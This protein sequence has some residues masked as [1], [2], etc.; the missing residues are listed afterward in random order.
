M[1]EQVKSSLTLSLCGVRR[2]HTM[3]MRTLGLMWILCILV[4][5]PS[6]KQLAARQSSHH[7]WPPPQWPLPQSVI[8]ADASNFSWKYLQDASIDRKTGLG[9]ATPK[10]WDVWFDTGLSQGA[11]IDYLET[12]LR[13]AGFRRYYPD[14]PQSSPRC[15]GQYISADGLIE[16]ITAA[17]PMILASQ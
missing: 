10:I 6:C 16:V 11:W 15:T 17:N 13:P 9:S 3:L 8:P 1:N 7:T 2:G 14:D 4:V 5:L 12:S